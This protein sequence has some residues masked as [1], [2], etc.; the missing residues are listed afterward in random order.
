MD[1]LA[2]AVVGDPRS[3]VS[4]SLPDSAVTRFYKMTGSGNDFVFFDVRGGTPALFQL[5]DAA[6]ITAL[7]RRGT[8][9]GADGVVLLDRPEPDIVRI[10]Y[11]NRD[12]SRAALCGNATLCAA[13]LAVHV[14]A[15]ALDER[16]IIRTDAGD[17]GARVGPVA[18]PSFELGAVCELMA[19]AG[20]RLAGAAGGRESRIGYAVVGVPHLVVRVGEVDAVSLESRGAELRRPTRERPEGANVN[21]VSPTPEG[22]WRMRTFE[23]GVEAETLACGTGAVASAAVVRTWGEAGDVVVVRTRS[24]QPVA[25]SFDSGGRGATLT[26]EGRLVFEGEL[27]DW[28]S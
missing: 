25:V 27:R 10:V 19:D 21:F 5:P 4:L 7:C 6:A 14:G 20:E 23:R 17:L 28:R 15:A 24:G 18:G 16:F 11:F 22:G 1:G 8:G 12:G 13:R 2:P 26:G 3:A 9:V